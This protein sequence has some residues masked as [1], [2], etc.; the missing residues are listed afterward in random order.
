MLVVVIMICISESIVYS[1]D[2]GAGKPTAAAP[3]VYRTREGAI[4]SLLPLGRIPNAMNRLPWRC[5]HSAVRN[6]RWLGLVSESF[7]SNP[8][9]IS[10]VIQDRSTVALQPNGHM[11][12]NIP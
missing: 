2:R 8:V 11:L 5:R 6:P 3:A 12:T 4:P 7:R 9:P 1:L 10:L